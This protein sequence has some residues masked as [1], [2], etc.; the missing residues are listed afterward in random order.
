[1]KNSQETPR[2]SVFL[3]AAKLQ[4]IA[5]V[6]KP[7]DAN[8]YS[9]YACDNLAEAAHTLN[10]PP[11]GE[12]PEC[13]MFETYFKPENLPKY[14]LYWWPPKRWYKSRRPRTTRDIYPC[15]W[16]HESRILA[17]LLCAEMLRR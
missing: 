6:E 17:L 4:F 15:Q 8:N 16:D 11:Y 1:M 7:S 13:L 14:Q 2:R 3:L 9:N 10:L 12:T 5:S